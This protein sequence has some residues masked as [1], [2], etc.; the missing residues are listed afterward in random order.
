MRA[1]IANVVR[2]DKGLFEPPLSTKIISLTP[3]YLKRCKS[4]S[5]AK[6]QTR[7]AV[8]RHENS[9]QAPGVGGSAQSSLRIKLW[10]DTRNASTSVAKRHFREPQSGTRKAPK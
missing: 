3:N 5:V 8:K 2:R 9:P 7:G 1:R 4:P 10:R 6:R